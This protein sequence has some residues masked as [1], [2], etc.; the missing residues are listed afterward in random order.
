MLVSW[1]V[2]SV[3]VSNAGSG[4]TG[5]AQIGFAAAGVTI[6]RDGDNKSK[7]LALINAENTTVADWKALGATRSFSIA[8][9]G[10][11]TLDATPNLTLVTSM[12][13]V[14]TAI[15]KAIND[16]WK[17][18]LAVASDVVK[19]SFDANRLQFRIQVVNVDRTID[20]IGHP[21][22]GQS[23]FQAGAALLQG[24]IVQV[25]SLNILQ[26]NQGVKHFSIAAD[27]VN[28]GFIYVGGSL[29]PTYGATSAVGATD[30]VARIFYI[31]TAA[32]QLAEEQ[33]QVVGNRANGT[34]P[35]ADSRAI[36]LDS[37]GTIFYQ[38]DD[39]GIFRLFD[40]AAATRKWV[41]VNGN[42]ALS[43]TSSLAYDALND[44]L[45]NG[46]QDVG[47]QIQTASDSGIWKTFSKGD[48]NAQGVG[49]LRNAAGEPVFV[50]RYLLGNTIDTLQVQVVDL[51]NNV[52][53]MTKQKFKS[54]AS[55]ATNSALLEE[56]TEGFVGAL[57]LA[58]N[59]IDPNKI[60]ISGAKR[61]YESFDRG[62]TVDYVHADMATALAYGGWKRDGASAENV[63]YAAFNDQIWWRGPAGGAFTQ[64]TGQPVGATTITN[65]VMDRSNWEVAYAVDDKHVYATI[66]GGKNWTDITPAATGNASLPVDGLQSLELAKILQKTGG[67][68]DAGIADIRIDLRDGT[69]IPVNLASVTTYLQLKTAI[70]TATNKVTVST[71]AG[72][73]VLTGA[74]GGV[75]ARVV[76]L[77]NSLAARDLKLLADQATIAANG[78]TITGGVIS[79]GAIGD[80]TLLSSLNVLARQDRRRARRL[81]A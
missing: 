44:I 43:E 30:W 63:A 41:S 29:Q 71:A 22:T 73:I 12:D 27:P 32:G 67:L 36:L 20:A 18:K 23:L 5:I 19:V 38:S 7:Q 80:A 13:D 75:L 57:P 52:L 4:F 51:N 49:I 2:A 26:K 25:K 65:I 21:A 10:Q 62:M 8:I 78:S 9:A 59:A 39:G 76:A 34:A 69:S 70:E 31:N 1:G 47:N 16:K 33:I 68:T 64:A 28:P 45:F 40:R 42:L 11:G 15:E 72:K 60:F 66:D 56:E 37:S 77:N 79:S 3:A 17:A 24:S 54:D 55:A 46:A 48:G 14:A 6:G 74:N 58:V 53:R 81:A 35:H 50:L 61:T